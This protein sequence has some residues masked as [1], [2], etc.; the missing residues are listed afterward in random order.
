MVMIS[1]LHLSIYFDFNR[2]KDFHKFCTQVI[3]II[4]PSLVLASGDL[5][6]AIMRSYFAS[7]QIE[8]EWIWY[9]EVLNFSGVTN[10]TL[11][12]DIRGNHDM[13]NIYS[14]QSENNYFRKYS[15]TGSKYRRHF[16][17][18]LK[19]NTETY[20]FIAVDAC[21]HP[22][23][24]RP[25]NFMG[26]LKK[27]DINKL[28]NLSN[29]AKAKGSNFTIWFGHYPTS[30]IL[31][32]NFG[33]RQILNGPY[34]CGH[35][36]AF[37][38]QLYITHDNDALEIEVGD[39]KDHR[40]FRIA[41]IDHGLFSFNDI[42]LNEWPII[43]ITNPKSALFSMSRI[44]PLHRI[45]TSS[46]IRA[47]VFSIFAIQSV[48]VKIDESPWK[49]MRLSSNSLYVLE[50]KPERYN[51]GLHFITV[52]AIDAKNNKQFMKQQFSIDGSKPEFSFFKKLLLRGSLQHIFKKVFFLIVFSS[53]L[54]LMAFRTIHL[55]QKEYLFQ[56]K[57]SSSFV[58]RLFY[59][60]CLMASLDMYAFILVAIPF[61]VTSG[62]W[63]IGDLV[64]NHFG[65][66]FVWGLFIDGHYSPS[67]F[68]YVFGAAFVLFVNIA[69][70]FC[71][72]QIIY[73]RHE[74]ILAKEAIDNSFKQKYL[75]ARH[76]AFLIICLLHL[77]PISILETSFGFKSLIFGFL[78]TWSFFIYAY[79]WLSSFKL[80]ENDFSRIDDNIKRNGCKLKANIS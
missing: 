21:Y 57:E 31:M 25:F 70:T 49:E 53:I 22:S 37:I 71:F 2:K 61:Y 11:W 39:W 34:L 17:Y 43:L 56:S 15:E 16:S 24:K 69:H 67:C 12:L 72:A 75:K 59:K 50:W 54:P 6:D 66:C 1:D 41:A 27:D 51:A 78:F 13:F 64:D 23:Q 52:K 3:S 46:H 18:E 80:D 19:H 77:V 26:W 48:H 55:Y 36:H 4:K 30:S 68:T 14:W 10:K 42:H 29:E 60:F 7:D 47:L 65:L 79:L 76:V 32:P 63:F 20:T 8:K 45:K 38:K 40:F 33:L 9:R 44:E 62:P 28:T 5:T 73:K 74:Q 35:Y 58:H